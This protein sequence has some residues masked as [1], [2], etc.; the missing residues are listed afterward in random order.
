MEMKYNLNVGSIVLRRE[1]TT[2]GLCKVVGLLSDCNYVQGFQMKTKIKTFGFLKK[3]IKLAHSYQDWPK[4][5]IKNYVIC[6]NKRL[7]QEFGFKPSETR[8][9]TMEYESKKWKI[10]I[11]CLYDTTPENVDKNKF[12]LIVYTK[13]ESMMLEKSWCK[14]KYMHDIQAI[15]R[16][17]GCDC[18]KKLVRC[19]EPG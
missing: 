17:V 10:E 18:P 4:G 15:L 9:N 16:T 3:F 8:Q 1:D 2:E 19:T 7:L 6:I 14:V 11:Y 5:N 13:K 12:L